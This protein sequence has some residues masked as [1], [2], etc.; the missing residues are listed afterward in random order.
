MFRM[1]NTYE[2]YDGTSLGKSTRKVIYSS[3]F[4]FCYQSSSQ[5]LFYI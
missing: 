4:M 5:Y 3:S 1:A 2:T